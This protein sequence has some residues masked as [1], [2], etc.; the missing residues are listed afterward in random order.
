MLRM[1][2]DQDEMMDMEEEEF[3]GP[4]ISVEQMPMWGDCTDES[5]TQTEIMKY[6]KKF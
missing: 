4:F 1:E 5:C 2:T 6:I 3:S